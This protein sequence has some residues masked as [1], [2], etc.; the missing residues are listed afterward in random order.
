MNKP[1]QIISTNLIEEEQG[2]VDKILLPKF[3]IET[4]KIKLL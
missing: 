1:L 3:A 4:F 2:L